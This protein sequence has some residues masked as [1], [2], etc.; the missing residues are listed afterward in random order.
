MRVG[1]LVV[2]DQTLF[3]RIAIEVVE[4]TP[5]FEALGEAASGEEALALVAE[6]QPRAHLAGR[7]HARDGRDRDS[8]PPTLNG[9][10]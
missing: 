9:S 3:R 1:V 6:L 8:P 7:P 10:Y 5:G 4:A 2:D